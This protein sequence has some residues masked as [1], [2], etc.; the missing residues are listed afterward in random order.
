MLV[1]PGPAASLGSR[2]LSTIDRHMKQSAMPLYRPSHTV[3]AAWVTYC[4]DQAYIEPR[5]NVSNRDFIF[6]RSKLKKGKLTKSGIPGWFLNK[7]G[8]LFFP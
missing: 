4:L 1:S 6:Y 8:Y 7:I 5:Q 2:S 3:G